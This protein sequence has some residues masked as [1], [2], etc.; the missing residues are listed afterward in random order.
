MAVEESSHN[1]NHSLSE[2]IIG[3]EELKLNVTEL[4]VEVT[5]LGHMRKLFQPCHIYEYNIHEAQIHISKVRTKCVE[6]ATRIDMVAETLE[7]DHSSRTAIWRE[8]RD[9]M[10]R[11]TVTYLKVMSH[12][13]YHVRRDSR[14]DNK[15]HDIK[16]SVLQKRQLEEYVSFS[17][18]KEDMCATCI[19][20]IK[21]LLSLRADAF[22]TDQVR[23]S[24]S[25]DSDD[26][27]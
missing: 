19:Q 12:K 20:K 7:K 13:I 14:W 3:L 15:L 6:T 8:T 23:G 2:M 1:L 16:A 9:I 10:I 4:I 5:C 21:D 25:V 18:M 22:G 24:T 17:E 27:P 11:D 26:S